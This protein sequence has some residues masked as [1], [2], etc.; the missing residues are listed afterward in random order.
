MN[1][2]KAEYRTIVVLAS[3]TLLLMSCPLAAQVPPPPP[4][5]PPDTVTL[6]VSGG[7]LTFNY[8]IGSTVPGAQVL[9][10]S[11]STGTASFAA[12]PNA[13]W[14]QVSPTSGTLGTSATSLSVSINPAGLSPTTY[15]GTIT[16]TS[17]EVGRTHV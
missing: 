4:P 12:T 13:S 14:L 10:A 8:Q 2:A 15:N 1:S 3:F 11:V 9:N 7:P 5:P 16:I 6:T 17:S